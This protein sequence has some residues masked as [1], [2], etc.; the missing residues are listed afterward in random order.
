[1]PEEFYKIQVF[2]EN[3]EHDIKTN[4]NPEFTF[5]RELNQFEDLSPTEFYKYFFFFDNLDLSLEFFYK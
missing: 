1:M 5:K 3:Y 4:R 2:Y